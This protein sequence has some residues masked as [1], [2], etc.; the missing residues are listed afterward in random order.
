M[1]GSLSEAAAQAD[2]CMKF[3]LQISVGIFLHISWSRF[4]SHPEICHFMTQNLFLFRPHLT[5]QGRFWRFRLPKHQRPRSCHPECSTRD[6]FFEW[7]KIGFSV[8]AECATVFFPIN[9]MATPSRTP[10]MIVM[11]LA[12]SWKSHQGMQK[13]LLTVA[14]LSGAFFLHIRLIYAVLVSVVLNW[15]WGIWHWKCCGRPFR[16]IWSKIFEGIFLSTFG[17]PINQSSHQS[18]NRTNE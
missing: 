9:I 7:S 1:P 16:E 3:L 5:I 6:L 13:C 14:L 2:I 15:R 12:K 4:L 10:T 17:E 11:D 18:I 8:P